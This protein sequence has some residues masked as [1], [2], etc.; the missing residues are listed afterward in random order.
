MLNL[1]EKILSGQATMEDLD[2]LKGLCDLVGDTSLCA[3]GQTAPNPVLTTLKYFEHEYL[4]Y[5]RGHGSTE[6]LPTSTPAG[7]GV[8]Q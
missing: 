7:G 5:L 6:A 1:L 8:Q 3:L 2:R 4:A